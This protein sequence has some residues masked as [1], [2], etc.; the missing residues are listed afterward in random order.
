MAPD[1]YKLRKCLKEHNYYKISNHLQL[2]MHVHRF[3]TRTESKV[4]HAKRSEEPR[5][6]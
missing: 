6:V 2:L 5:Q 3:Y 4:A 1:Y